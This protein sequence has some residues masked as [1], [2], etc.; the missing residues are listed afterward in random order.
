MKPKFIIGISLIAV[1]MMAVITFA[2][3][4][5]S[6]LEV[7]VDELYSRKAKTADITQQSLK[8][9]GIVVGDSIV[10]D[11]TTLRLEF[12]VVNSRAELVN[13]LASAKR[14]R[15]VHKG[16]KPDTLMNEAEAIV[17]GK[18]AGDGRFYAANTPDAL[19]LQ[20]PTKYVDE[21]AAK[22]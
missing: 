18:L 14:L 10:Y 15:V 11:P 5:N 2:I 6:S 7:G 9:R 22:K 3:L 8:I 19:L 1:A 12:D 17:T 13:N 20:C 16:T 21:T 4:G